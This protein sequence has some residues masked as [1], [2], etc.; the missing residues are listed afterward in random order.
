MTLPSRSWAFIQKKKHDLKIYIQHNI[1][2]STAYNSQ[3][4]EA[5]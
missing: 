5:I 2:C 4:M 3:D 1:H